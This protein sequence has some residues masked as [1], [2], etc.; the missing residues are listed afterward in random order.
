VRFP[1][2]WARATALVGSARPGLPAEIACWRSSDASVEAA[3]TEARVAAE[4]LAARLRTGEPFP[5]SYS[6][7]DG[8]PLRE[9]LIEVVASEG[10]EPTVAVT[11]NSYGCLVLNTARTAFVDVDLDTASASNTAP[12]STEPPSAPPPRIGRTLFAVMFGA[13]APRSKTAP[14]PQPAPPEFLRRW[15]EADA[16]RGA[17]VYRTAAGFRY[18]LTHATFDPTSPE[19]AE[20]LAALDSDP[21]YR[22]LC[23]AQRS[24]RAR[25]TP[26][27]WRC[28]AGSL[29]VPFPR[30]DA[31]RAERI[32]RMLRGY[33]AKA[34]RYATCALVAALGSDRIDPEVAAVVAFHDR[35]TRAGSKLPLA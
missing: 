29:R 2:H 1:K 31:R 20:M 3:E 24:F 5:G 18:L 21:L 23:A 30:P 10:G 19:T 28:G 15:I 13:A 35:A 26:K 11:R 7:G 4:S 8:R 22:R 12:V 9:E 16:R 6:Y 25:L 33:E 32:E 34:A 27:P 14:P 17:R